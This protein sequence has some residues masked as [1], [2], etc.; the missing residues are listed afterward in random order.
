MTLHHCCLILETK[1]EPGTKSVSIISAMWHSIRFE[2]GSRMF[3]SGP[4]DSIFILINIAAKP[5]MVA[6]RSDCSHRR[7]PVQIPLEAKTG[8]SM[9]KKIDFLAKKDLTGYI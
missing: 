4:C 2:S 6:E 9:F 1:T 3:E 7:P 5:A 8:L